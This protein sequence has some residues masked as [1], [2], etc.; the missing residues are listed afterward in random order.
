MDNKQWEVRYRNNLELNMYPFDGMVSFW[1]RNKRLITKKTNEKYKICELGCGCGNNLA[2]FAEN[3]CEV[4]GI[5]ISP[6]AIEHAKKMFEKKKLKGHF[7]V[8]NLINHPFE[9]DYFDLV[10]ERGC[11]HHNPGFFNECFNTAYS[12]LKPNGLFYSW[13]YTENNTLLKDADK[14]INN[15]YFFY[16]D[17][18][19]YWYNIPLVVYDDSIYEQYLSKLNIIILDTITNEDIKNNKIQNKVVVGIKS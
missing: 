7:F 5:D 19:H 6:T 16:S 2:F 8:E 17:H 11:F 9:N 14:V 15:E 12:I 4:Y 3:D 18:S 13:M 1:F 10:I